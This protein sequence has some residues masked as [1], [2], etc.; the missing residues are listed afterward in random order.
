[1]HHLGPESTEDLG[2]IIVQVAHV[3]LQVFSCTTSLEAGWRAQF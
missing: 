2:T 3:D 1:M